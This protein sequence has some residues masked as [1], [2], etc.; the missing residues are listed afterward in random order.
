MEVGVL[1]PSTLLHSFN[2]KLYLGPTIK[3]PVP[4]KAM[5]C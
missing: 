2:K 1:Q 5:K 3:L 4:N